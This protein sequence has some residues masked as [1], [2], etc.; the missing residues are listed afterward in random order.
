[1]ITLKE[2]AEKLNVSIST[3][4]K[5][6]NGSSEIGE[7]TIAR[8]KETA[9]MYNYKPNRVALS[10]KNSKTKTIGVIIPNI[11]NHFFAKVLYGIEK[12]SAKQG[13]NIIT[14]LSNELYEKEAN[15]LELL[16]NGS[17]D[18]FI[19]SIAEETEVNKK[20]DHFKDILNQKIPI[21][22]FDRVSQAITCDKVVNNDFQA[23]YD[24]TMHLIK[25][26]RKN[27]ILINKIE[28]LSVGKLRSKG[29]F[30]AIEDAKQY[31]SNLTEVKIPSTE[32]V[33]VAIE[34]YFDKKQPID[35]VICI[36]NISGGAVLNIAK[37]RGYSIPQD[38]S[39]IGFSDDNVLPFTSPKLSTIAQH[40]DAIGEA[41]VQILVNR[42]ESKE[43]VETV[44]KTID[45]S[46]NLRETTL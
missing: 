41:S 6:L 16:A 12:E 46:L 27:I 40:S 25:E 32:N 30:K 5:A 7:A 26:G 1:M 29:C 42:L 17:V 28:E 24:A 45:F 36:D 15:S 43:P 14:C 34:N 19:M 18:G 13:Y 20:T 11:L 33:E 22:M 9:K 3:V 8:V 44:F 4:S 38:M 10:L 39:I 35:G 21:L 2:L 23:A 31:N 37:E